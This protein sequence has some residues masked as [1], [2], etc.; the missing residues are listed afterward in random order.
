MQRDR[1]NRADK[2]GRALVFA[3]EYFISFNTEI[4][5]GK[6]VATRVRID[7]VT[8]ADM[9]KPL[10]IDLSCHPLYSDLEKYVKGNPGR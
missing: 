10:H 1:R 2:R 8:I 6:I 3:E 9:D 5:P 7:Q 4:E